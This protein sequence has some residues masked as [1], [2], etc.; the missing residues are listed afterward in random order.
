MLKDLSIEELFEKVPSAFARDKSFNTSSRYTYISTMEIVC[1]L[2]ESGY[3]P[4]QACQSRSK[5]STGHAKHMI[6]FR[7]SDFVPST[8]GLIPELILINSHD[9]TSAYR[10][11][12]GLYRQV[13][14]NGLMAGKEYDDISIRHQGNII[15]KVLDGTFEIMSSADKLLETAKSM[16]LTN[17]NESQKIALAEKAHFIRFQDNE[18]GENFSPELLLTPRRFQ[19]HN[20]NDLFST[21][22]ILQENLIKGG[23]QSYT[24]DRDGF[25]R[26]KS[27]RK[28]NSI[29]KSVSINRQLW[30]LAQDT[31]V[32]LAA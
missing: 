24:R 23:L 27:I 31:L 17:L 14:S 32:K 28:V 16:E 12:A 20:K 19:E 7:R 15:K 1:S 2:I 9:G 11:F 29:D 18:L 22:N 3:L 6:R 4:T 5:L 10:L 8:S 13:C 21:F 26:R 25:L 30:S